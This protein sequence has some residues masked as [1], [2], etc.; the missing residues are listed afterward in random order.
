M[1]FIVTICMVSNHEL[2]DQ[3]VGFVI[4]FVK[5]E[6]EKI[7]SFYLMF[8]DIEFDHFIEEWVP[9]IQYHLGFISFDGF[10]VVYK[11]NFYKWIY[12]R[13]KCYKLHVVTLQQNT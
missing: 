8:R 7:N 10:P 4:V 9:I 3:R 1:L 6:K 11:R 12:G 2:T 5:N 13:E